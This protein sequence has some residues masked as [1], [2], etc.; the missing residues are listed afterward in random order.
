MLA[1]V[2]DG[3]VIYACGNTARFTSLLWRLLLWSTL[4]RPHHKGFYDVC[5]DI[6]NLTGHKY[7]SNNTKPLIWWTSIAINCVK[8]TTIKQLPRSLNW[9][10]WLYGRH[11]KC[12]TL[13]S[14]PTYN[15]KNISDSLSAS[16]ITLPFI[17]VYVMITL[18]VVNWFEETEILVQFYCII[19]W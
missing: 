12:E 7:D 15:L 3:G 4:R 16:Q 6:Y 17:T 19:L 11:S 2:Y 10:Q 14:T 8:A 13:T 5:R 1:I 18:C 9:L